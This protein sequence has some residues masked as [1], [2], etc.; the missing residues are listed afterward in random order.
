MAQVYK[1]LTWIERLLSELKEFMW[2]RPI[3]HHKKSEN[4]L[5]HIFACFLALYLAALLRHKL[6]AAGVE[7][8]WDEVIRGPLQAA[9]GRGR[10]RRAALP[11]AQ[12]PAGVRGARLQ[13]RRGEG[14]AACHAPVGDD[15]TRGGV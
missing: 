7:A 13:R 2:L 12:P 9:R 14:A 5:G 11:A 4:V 3:F 10:A 1:Q 6:A 8:Q 15:P